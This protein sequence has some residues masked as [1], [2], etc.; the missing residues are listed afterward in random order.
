[1][2]LVGIC[3]R[4]VIVAAVAAVLAS[5]PA[6][7]DASVRVVAPAFPELVYPAH[8]ATITA[9]TVRLQ[10]TVPVAGEM[11]QLVMERRAADGTYV[12]W[13]SFALMV[14]QASRLVLL[15]A[16]RYRWHVEATAGSS[17]VRGFL[18]PP[19]A[20]L[21]E[22]VVFPTIV[23][24][25]SSAGDG[26]P[27]EPY[28]EIRTRTSWRGNVV[29]AEVRVKV[30][31]DGV[32][33]RT[34][35]S[36]STAPQV[37][38]IQTRSIRFSMPRRFEGMRVTLVFSLV[39]SGP[40]IALGRQ[41]VT[42]PKAPV[43]AT[44][45]WPTTFDGWTVILEG[46]SK[47]TTSMATAN[48]RAADARAAGLAAGVLDSNDFTSLCPGFWVVFHGRVLTRDAASRLLDEATAAGYS[49]AYVRQVGNASTASCV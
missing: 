36:T 7:A 17:G 8:G 5:L 42:V 31:V 24:P 27:T 3:V 34:R 44:L 48:A 9:E 1:M 46:F 11:Q 21:R 10:W 26:T 40:V 20:K 2:R 29:P 28:A 18:V 47:S 39:S 14:D 30:F 33:K 35:M 16:A 43:V 12:A 41:A 38:G 32:L 45:T 22:T 23:V 19:H 4:V 13:R 49:A 6:T 15:P 25:D 37:V